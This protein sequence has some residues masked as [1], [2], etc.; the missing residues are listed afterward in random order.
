MIEYGSVQTFTFDFGAEFNSE[1]RGF[2]V[3]VTAANPT[4][5]GYMT[6]TPVA[7]TSEPKTS[8][9][10]YVRG[11]TAANQAIVSSSSGADG[12]PR[13][14][15]SNVETGS[16]RVRM[17]VDLIGIYAI[18]DA[19]GLRFSPLPPSRILDTR[20]GIGGLS[21][22]FGGPETQNFVPDESVRTPNTWGMVANITGVA[23]TDNTFLSVFAGGDF[24][25]VTSSVNI[26]AKHT[27]SNAVLAPLGTS[28]TV[29]IRNNSGSLMVLMDVSGRLEC[30][31]DC[32]IARNANKRPIRRKA[33]VVETSRVSGW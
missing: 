9:V 5:N 13:F 6:A 28:S 3:N 16:D 19:T 26:T 18:D 4:G 32:Q 20:S 12:R 29:S 24:W 11:D 21:G 27:R 14:S 25:P 15:V 33:P 31:D 8:T 1:V 2:L 30:D 17:I 23:A 10:S 22:P 7:P